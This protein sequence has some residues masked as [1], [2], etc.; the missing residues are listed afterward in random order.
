MRNRKL[1]QRLIAAGLLGAVLLTMTLG[2]VWTSPA[3]A[4]EDDND[5]D[6]SADYEIGQVVVKLD[7]TAGATIAD[8]NATYGT[9][10]IAELLYS[11]GIYL[12]QVPPG[13]DT[14]DVA[15]AMENDARLLYAE[16]NFTGEAPESGGNATWAWG[17]QDSAPFFEQY[18]L[19]VLG[20]PQAHEISRG[21]GAVVAVLDTGVQLD[22]PALAASLTAAR[23]DFVDDDPLP[24][25]EPNGL[26]DDGDS[27]VDEGVGH[28]THVAGVVHLVAPEAQIMPL[29]VLDSDGCGNVFTI[30]KAVTYAAD[31]G[32]AVINLS[33]GMGQESELLEDVIKDVIEGG[34]VVVAAAGNLNTDAEQYPAAEGDALAVTSVGPGDIKSAFSNFG[35]W[36]HVAAPGE[37]IYSTLPASGYGW[38][39]GTSM[40]TPFVAGQAALIRSVAPSLLPEDIA[41]Q[42]CETAQ[43]LDAINPEFAGLLGAGRVDVGASLQSLGGD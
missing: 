30:A 29:R 21:A 32:A 11:A 34:V 23:Y 14:K 15:A 26:D 3:Y 22:H 1:L 42:I 10:T 20:L 12:L 5:D 7:P 9:T 18:A 39:S 43:P 38:W 17:G 36:M 13:E 19:D 40:A 37:S 35:D 2:A 6:I 4:D 31:N 27:F 16:P 41:A 33:L 28:G 25:D 8:V 24:E